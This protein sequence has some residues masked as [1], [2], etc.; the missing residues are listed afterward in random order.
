MGYCPSPVS[1]QV[2]QQVSCDVTD[3]IGGQRK[4]SVT[5]RNF[6]MSKV[7]K[8]AG[9]LL[10]L[11]ILAGVGWYLNRDA[12]ENA[13]VGDCLHQVSSNEVKIVKCDAA[14]ADFSVIGKVENKKQTEATETACAAFPE[15]AASYW[16]GKSGKDGDVL[17]LKA[18]KA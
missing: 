17:C 16:W 1:L 6:R 5:G 9:S 4:R 18:L 15:T 12:G 2:N 3:T 14:D 10:V 11:A 13:K 8:F 7:V